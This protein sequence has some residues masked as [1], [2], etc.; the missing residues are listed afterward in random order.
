[1]KWH[2]ASAWPAGSVPGDNEKWVAGK[3]YSFY[4][5]PDGL[6][7]GVSKMG[8]TT[9]FRDNGETWAQPSVPPTL[10]TGK[11]KVW[12]AD[13]PATAV[14]ALVYNPSP[15]AIATRSP[16]SPATTATFRDMRNPAGRTPHPAV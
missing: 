4:R 2:D 6:L 7:V 5:R 3:A 1:M 12:S 8:W 9:T 15:S 11:A 13:P 16:S 14:P 10:V